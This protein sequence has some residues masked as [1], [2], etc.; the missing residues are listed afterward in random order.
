MGKIE[1]QIPC[2]STNR[3]IG[4][5]DGS[6]M[7]GMRA[8]IDQSRNGG[9]VKV[10]IIAVIIA[11]LIIAAVFI[12]IQLQKEETD[13]SPLAIGAVL[14]E[15]KGQEEL[16]AETQ[17][18]GVYTLLV[19]MDFTDLFQ[20][21][22]WELKEVDQPKE[23]TADL[24]ITVEAGH[25]IR[26]Y[27]EENI[28][29]TY[30]EDTQEKSRYYAIPEGVYDQI[31]SYV[32][33]N[34]NML[35]TE[36]LIQRYLDVVMS[37]PKE[38]SNSND[39]IEAHDLEYQKIVA[40]GEDAFTYILEELDAGSASGLKKVIMETLI[41]EMSGNFLAFPNEILEQEQTLIVFD[42]VEWVTP[43]DA[44]RMAELGITEEDMPGGFYIYNPHD[45]TV[46][47]RMDEETV[48]SII[49]LGE[50]VTTKRVD[51]ESFIEHVE[52][53]S[54]FIPPFWVVVKDGHIEEIEEQYVP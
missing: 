27:S 54:E 42:L 36:A 28:A 48:C 2:R 9:K 49:D 32:L 7:K 26:F 8:L 14:E 13:T 52:E 24:Q 40:M 50:E 15:L 19:E 31:R 39:Y 17:A 29:E 30:R 46:S 16:V 10:G 6:K 11:L 5:V 41:G 1:V 47:F 53:F 3:D 37:S 25:F 43:E 33:A 23:D 34:G 20:E 44:D 4:R 51:M 38:S 18:D 35:N 45:F 21:G 12:V 22:N